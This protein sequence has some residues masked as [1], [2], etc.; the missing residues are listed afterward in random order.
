M[1][2]QITFCLC[3][4]FSLFSIAAALDV[5]RHANRFAASDAYRWT[6]L[7]ENDQPVNDSNGIAL[8][9][10]ARIVSH[11]FSMRGV[12]PNVSVRFQSEEDERPHRIYLWTTPLAKR[13]KKDKDSKKGEQ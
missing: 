11:D 7:S 10:G 1:L 4:G 9:P 2:R 12:R 5:M 3:P 6:F 8:A 13:N